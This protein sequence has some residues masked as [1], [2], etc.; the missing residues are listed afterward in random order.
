MT[1]GGMIYTQSFMKTGTGVQ[2]ILSFVSAIL[3][4][5]MLVLL[6]EVFI[7]CAIEM[8]SDGKTY[9]SSFL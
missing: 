9:V 6:M 7:R 8:G 2:A 5:I 3:M 1:S 4:A